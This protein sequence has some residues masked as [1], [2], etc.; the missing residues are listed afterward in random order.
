MRVLAH[1]NVVDLFFFHSDF[2]LLGLN[3]NLLLFF[4]T[5]TSVILSVPIYV[6]VEYLDLRT[7]E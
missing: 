7:K 6:I 1:C 5:Q 3:G 2:S 4:K